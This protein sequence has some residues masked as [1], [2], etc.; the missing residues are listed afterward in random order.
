M[1]RSAAMSL[2]ADALAPGALA[3]R[4]APLG[5]VAPLTEL[6]LG[7]PELL[8]GEMALL[9]AQARELLAGYYVHLP[10]KRALYAVDPIGRLDVLAARISAVERGS[11]PTFPEDELHDELSAI[12]ASLRD[13]HTSYTLPE[14]HR[15]RIA[16]LPF[17]LEECDGGRGPCFPV[18]K[19]AGPFADPDFRPDPARPVL[20]THWNGVPI[21]R[22]V[23]RHAER[24][25]GSNDAARR[26]R[27]LERLTF[28]WLGRLVRPDED[29]VVVS[30]EVGGER[31]HLRFPW[32]VAERPPGPA[33][34]RGGAPGL[35]RGVDEEGEWI[36]AVKQE[37]FAGR[38]AWDD[39]PLS[40]LVAFRVITRPGDPRRFGHLRLFSFGMPP[41]QV[42]RYVRRVRR[43]I[44][45]AP[46]DGLVVD[47]RGNP[48]GD[49]VAAEELLQLL[50]PVP[51]QPLGM[52][53]LNTPQAGALA[54]R[55]YRARGAAG[56]FDDV[57]REAAATAA[58]FLP[59][60]PLQP[61]AA[62]NA[63]GQAYQGPVVLLVDALS[64]SA[65]DVFAASFQDHDLGP[66]VGTAP[67]TGGGGGN[68]WPYESIR[69]LAGRPMPRRLPGGASFDVAV[70]RTTRVGRRAGATL[71][72]R[73][74]VLGG[75][76]LPVTVADVLGT[77]EDLLAAALGALPDPPAPCRLEVSFRA[78]ERCFTLRTEGLARV[79]VVVDRRPLATVAD[80]D[81]ARI[82]L[83]A[84][85]EPQAAAFLGYA[86]PEQGP[87][88]AVSA[89]WRARRR[90]GRREGGADGGSGQGC[91]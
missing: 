48:G 56:H 57:L 33:S 76:P 55:V 21:E 17:L 89:R 20:V 39:V 51:I 46:P 59:S 10:L 1:G 28:R 52:D 75:G 84:G 49:I 74:V 27:G 53:F 30:Y 63:L 80:P 41:G 8:P 58:Q 16:F 9:V 88:P 42:R 47:L 12:F 40:G 43:L 15:S 5:R 35:R 77:N 86:T 34:P 71:E 26:A 44:A 36:R 45:Q 70:R 83:P 67:Q 81:G 69:R 65:A 82:A 87:A 4:L 72:D 79:E 7:R 3:A 25:G 11:A 90:A 64:Y 37:L 68:V 24:T 19:A 62:Y 66:V 54:E 29:W 50:S 61:R 13:L 6:D 14:P 91:A 38:A 31:R 73:G 78:R 60:P 2:V 32:L 22:A 23:L 85:L 18:T